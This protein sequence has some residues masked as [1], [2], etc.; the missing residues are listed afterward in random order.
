LPS[1][2]SHS[3][4]RE[5]QPAARLLEIPQRIYDELYRQQTEAAERERTRRD[6]DKLRRK[7]TGRGSLVEFVKHFWHTLEPKTR[8][9]IE[10]WPLEAICLHLEAITFGDIKRVLI[11]VPPGFM[12]SLLTD[13]FWPAAQP[14]AERYGATRADVGKAS[15]RPAQVFFEAAP[16]PA[17]SDR[18]N[19][20][21]PLPDGLPFRDASQRN[22]GR[23]PP[24]A[25][26]VHVIG[27][28]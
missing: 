5:A 17:P 26:S 7:Q 8:K 3:L 9:L 24:S 22:R 13:V 18:R 25:H 27:I 1:N 11:N 15:S 4:L 23:L 6:F 28:R 21:A 20:P 12:K 16:P 2:N 14:A 10:G 19:A